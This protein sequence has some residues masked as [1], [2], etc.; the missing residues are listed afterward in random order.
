MTT[1]LSDRVFLNEE[2][3]ELRATLRRF[4]A[5]ELAPH[6][7]AWERART[8]PREIYRKVAEPG[9]LGIGIDEA[10]GGSGGDVFAVLIMAEEITRSGSPGLGASLGSLMIALPPILAAG[11]E[12]QK[13]RWITPVVRGEKIAA[14]AIT[15]PDAG[16]DVASLRT[17]ARRDGDH[18]VVNGSK[19]YITS[20]TRADILTTAVRTG[21][22]GAGGVS[23]LVIERDT[24]GVTVGRNLEKLGWHAS[25]TAELFFEDVRVPVDHLIGAENAGF[26]VLMQNFAMERLVLAA[27]AIEIARMAHEAAVAYS[28]SRQ[29]FGRPIGGF[30]VNRHRLAEMATGIETCAMFTYGVASRVQAGETLIAEVAMAKNAATDMA[31]QVVDAALQLHGGFGYMRDALVERLY[32]DIRLYPIGGGTREIMN[33]L[34]ARTI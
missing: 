2:H 17:H 7:D 15:E 5:R 19:T 9:Y 30:Q 18:Y 28:R 23:V 24:P 27:T 26:A 3:L 34:I 31:S 22:D 6:V 11:T 8:F 33:E 25:D 4:V 16:S 21:G 10:Y 13:C 12:A 14:L 20:G 32:R 1:R 29:A